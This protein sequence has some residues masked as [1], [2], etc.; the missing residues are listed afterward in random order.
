MMGYWGGLG[1]GPTVSFQGSWSDPISTTI[2]WEYTLIVDGGGAVSQ[3]MLRTGWEFVG[4]PLA[5]REVNH[6]RAREPKL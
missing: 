6:L 3:T 5:L 4:T 2:G 1:C